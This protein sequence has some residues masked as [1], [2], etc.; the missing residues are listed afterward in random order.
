MASPAPAQRLSSLFQ[1]S[2]ILDVGDL[3]RALPGRSRRSLYRDLGA[4][5]Y[6]TSYTHAG[7]YYTLRELASFDQDG[8][9][10]HQGVGF[11]VHGTLKA[12]CHHMVEVA[13]AGRTHGELALPLRVR[14]HNTLLDLVHERGIS[15]QSVGPTFLYVSA[16]RS[17]AAA[18]VQKRLEILRTEQPLA[19]RTASYLVIE[20]LLELVRSSK[21]LAFSTTGITRRLLARG[22]GITPE[23]VAEVLRE[24]GIVKKGRHSRSRS[25]RR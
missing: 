18:Q 11:S 25:S 15:R 24:H 3:E 1:R 21:D 2:P 10:M 9:W 22:V 12:T 16:H 14:V 19:A 17:R 8:L 7:G 4:L 5:D 13:V 6:L 20:V 23:Q